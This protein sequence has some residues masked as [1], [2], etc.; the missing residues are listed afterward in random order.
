MFDQRLIGIPFVDGGR[1]FEG[2][3]CW[4][5][6]RLAAKIIY[7]VDFPDYVIT[8]FDS[9]GIDGYCKRDLIRQWKP[10]KGPEECAIAIMGTDKNA[11]DLMNHIGL[12]IGR[13]K[14][15]HTLK[16]QHSHIERIDHPF[17]RKRIKGYWR[18]VG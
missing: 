9:I 6:V 1:T 10:I 5:L 8:C 14:M 12:V 17:Y 13:N 11:P 7:N 15:L 16:K 2:C 3:D 18:Y 4:G